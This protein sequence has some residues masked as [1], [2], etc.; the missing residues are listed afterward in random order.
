MTAAQGADMH[1][2]DELLRE[3]VCEDKDGNRVVVGEYDR[4][5]QLVDPDAPVTHVGPYYRLHSGEEA[6]WEGNEVFFIPDLDLYLRPTKP[7][8][9]S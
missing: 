9:P 5:A 4:A 8:V 6:I 1:K 7:F 2:M 3:I